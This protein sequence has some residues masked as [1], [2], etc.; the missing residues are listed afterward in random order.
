MGET[1]VRAERL[2]GPWADSVGWRHEGRGDDPCRLRATGISERPS[3]L[4]HRGRDSSLPW[5]RN[6][7]VVLEEEPGIDGDERP[8]PRAAPVTNATLPSSLLTICSFENDLREQG[9]PSAHG[10]T[11]YWP[12]ERCI[13]ALWQMFTFGT[14]LA[15]CPARRPASPVRRA[16]PDRHRRG[17][18]PAAAR[19]CTRR[20]PRA[21]HLGQDHG[22]APR[23]PRRHLRSPG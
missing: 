9:E 23:Q 17:R 11:L 15:R 18:R 14:L 20:R 21:T 16:P 8:S 2:T 5:R 13:T 6:R 19:L 7:R 22:A 3:T 10:S 12:N 1:A 4:T